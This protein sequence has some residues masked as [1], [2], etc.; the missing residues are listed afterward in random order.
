[1]CDIAIITIVSR[2]SYNYEGAQFNKS[3]ELCTLMISASVINI[4]Y[5][6]YNDKNRQ[7]YFEQWTQYR[8]ERIYLLPTRLSMQYRQSGRRQVVVNRGIPKQ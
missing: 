7:P 3:I 4:Q 5:F 6:L 8:K 1:M 2:R